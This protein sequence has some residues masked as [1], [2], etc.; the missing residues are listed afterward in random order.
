MD[1]NGVY[2][3]GYQSIRHRR[4]VCYPDIMNKT[5]ITLIISLYLLNVVM[6][7]GVIGLLN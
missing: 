6:V 4:K 5:D 7:L 2:F 1:E 3:S